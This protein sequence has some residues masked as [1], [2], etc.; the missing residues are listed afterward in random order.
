[1]WN[2]HKILIGKDGVGDPRLGPR[3]EPQDADR[4]PRSLKAL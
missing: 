4:P 3:T 1:V 2:F